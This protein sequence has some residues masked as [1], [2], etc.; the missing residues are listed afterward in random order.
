MLLLDE[1]DSFLGERGAQQA[2]W[3]T[4]QTN[5]LLTQMEAYEGVFICTSNRL[6]QLDP[7][8]LR[9]FDLKVGFAAL[10]SAQRLALIRQAAQTLGIT[11][12]PQAETDV[13]R[14]QSQLSGLTPGDLVAALRH[15]QLTTEAPTLTDLLAA[16]AAECGYKAPPAR[17]I[18]FVA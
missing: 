18:G 4:T 7:A 1:A 6:D 8:A 10:L 9:R 14:A 13:G 11:W 5:E 2:R 12:N 15:L 3:V 17:R 16:L